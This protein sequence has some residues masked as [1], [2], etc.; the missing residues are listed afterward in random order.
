MFG[1]FKK[2]KPVNE[3]QTTLHP[4]R[5]PQEQREVKIDSSLSPLQEALS[6]GKEKYNKIKQ[7][8]IIK[9]EAWCDKNILIL[10]EKAASEGKTGLRIKADDV[11]GIKLE[12]IDI[13]KYIGVYLDRTKELRHSINYEYPSLKQ[14]PFITIG[15]E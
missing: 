9:L 10:V 14:D 6:R 11:S 8:E 4:Y 15:W 7:A 1:L 13:V 3:Q 5:E 2:N 12:T